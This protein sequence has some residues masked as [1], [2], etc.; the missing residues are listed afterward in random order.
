[1]VL[2]PLLFRREGE[3]MK[4]KTVAEDRKGEATGG[5]TT[6]IEDRDGEVAG[7][8]GPAPKTPAPKTPAPKTP[9]TGIDSEAMASNSGRGR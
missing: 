7:P 2:G 3:F 1:V 6:E 9:A 4:G 8:R 5:S